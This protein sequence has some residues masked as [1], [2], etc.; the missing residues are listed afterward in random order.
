MKTV[1]FDQ[2]LAEFQRVFQLAASGETVVI[3]RDEQRVALHR[4]GDSPSQDMAP[5]AFFAEDYSADE[6]HE[7]NRLASQGPQALIP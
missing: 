7:L 6:I 1:S 2:A 3:E 4:V 5:L